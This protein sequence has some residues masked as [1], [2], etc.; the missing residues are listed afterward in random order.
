MQPSSNSK[1]SRGLYALLFLACFSIV[2]AILYFGRAILIPIALSILITFI[3]SPVV[4][5]LRRWGVGQYLSVIITV[6]LALSLIGS[7][8]TVI[9]FEFKGL[10][11]ELPAYR[12]NIR[13]KISDIRSASKSESL[14]KIKAIAE[15]IAGELK[16][17]GIPAAQT[18]TSKTG[19]TNA[20][21]MVQENTTVPG[22]IPAWDAWF[23]LLGSVGL[24]VVLVI[25]M[26]LRREDLRDRLLHLGGRERLVATTR[27]I[28]E[29]GD[30]VSRYLVRQCLLNSIYGVGIALGLFL[31]G[32]PYAMLWGF[33]AAIARFIPYAGP[34]IGAVAPMVMSLAVF[35]SWAS[36]LIVIGLILGWELVNNMI[37]EPVIYGQGIGVSEVALLI[38]MAFWT[39]LWG[40]LGLVLAAPLTVCMMVICKGVPE[41]NFISLLLGSKAAL[42]PQHSLYQRLVAQNFDEASILVKDFLKKHSRNELFETLLLPVLRTCRDDRA[43]HRLSGR[44]Q[45]Q[46]LDMLRQLLDETRGRPTAEHPASSTPVPPPLIV[47]CPVKD[48][49][50]EMALVLLAD[51][52]SE[53]N[54]SLPVISSGLDNQGKMAEIMALKPT[55]LC[56]GGLIDGDTYPAR[57]LSQHLQQQLPKMPIV[58]G[59]WGTNSTNDG[60]PNS[61][62]ASNVCTTL[63]DAQTKLLLLANEPALAHSDL[64]TLV[65]VS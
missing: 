48:A 33:F 6:V 11:N 23:E 36:P 34:V 44:M 3:L 27:A 46:V 1:R 56:L 31:I 18:S 35:D 30:K 61:N 47:G 25:F 60:L 26:L 4:T 20:P 13:Q 64:P 17:E 45:R 57:E 53:E 12:E 28:E 19:S 37:L 41:L 5:T 63:L 62:L 22:K 54:I 24:V 55:V 38:M 32:L 51:M 40:S 29:I 8:G 50:D 49:V 39:W 15:E 21:V 9:A 14:S 52:L 10:A 42:T 2:I 59:C 58:V 43:E 16:Q 7:I 65:N